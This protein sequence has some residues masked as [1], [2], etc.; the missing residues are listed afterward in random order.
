MAAEMV[1]FGQA[2]PWMGFWGSWGQLA[3]QRNLFGCQRWRVP[4]LLTIPVRCCDS[5]H[6]VLSLN[7]TAQGMTAPG[8]PKHKSEPSGCAGRRPLHPSHDTQT[9]TD[10]PTPYGGE[11]GA[12]DPPEV[13]L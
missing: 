3:G 7:T 12:P 4:R 1:L 6:F 8:F 10:L 5:W 13:E 2:M 9:A 11:L